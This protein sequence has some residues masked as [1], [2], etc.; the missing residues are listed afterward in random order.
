MRFC[1]TIRDQKFYVQTEENQEQLEAI[2]HRYAEWSE[3]CSSLSTYQSAIAIAINALSDQLKLEKEVAALKKENEA[4]QKK[5]DQWEK[6][7]EYNTLLTQIQKK[8][9]QDLS[10]AMAK[11]DEQAVCQKQ[12]LLNQ[13]HKAKIKQKKRRK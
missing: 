10:V 7:P 12:Q 13:V 9:E 8:M 4:L 2:Q 5:L 3:R 11:E 1:F 6:S